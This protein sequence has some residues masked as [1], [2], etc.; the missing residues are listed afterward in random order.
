MSQLILSEV[1]HRYP[2]GVLVAIEEEPRILNGIVVA[3]DMQFS[4]R[5]IALGAH[6]GDL[7]TFPCHINHYQRMPHALQLAGRI[8]KH[9]AGLHLANL[10]WL[11]LSAHGECTAHSVSVLIPPT[12]RDTILFAI[13]RISFNSSLKSSVTDE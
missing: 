10:P 12:G 1:E 13:E 6:N 8:D 9:I 5:R 11:R 7:I 4:G 2:E 3:H